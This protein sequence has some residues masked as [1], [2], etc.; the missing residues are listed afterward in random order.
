M[1]ADP[2]LDAG[3]ETKGG[4]NRQT[5]DQREQDP[6]PAKTDGYV[7]DEISRL[8]FTRPYL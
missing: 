5:C 4:E 2:S 1:F 8:C 3:I 6:P 7:L